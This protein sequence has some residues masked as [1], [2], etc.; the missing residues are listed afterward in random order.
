MPEQ[1]FHH[2]FNP[3][4]LPKPKERYGLHLALFSL[5]FL[6]VMWAGAEQATQW[7]PIFTD[8][9][10]WGRWIGYGLAYAIPFLGFLTVHEFGHYLTARRH[11][12]DAS[13]PYF[14]P[15]PFSLLGI[16]SI[17]TFGAVIRLR[18]T[19][20]RT[21][22]LFDIGI[23]GPLAG[24]V[25]A[26]GA[27]LYGLATLPDHTFV[28]ELPGHEVLKSF[29]AQHG[30]FPNVNEIRTEDGLL[31]IGQ[32]PLYAL[33]VQF[34]PN[35]P[36]MYEMYHYPILMAGWLGLF[37]TALNLMPVGQLDGGHIWYAL[38]G[39]RVHRIVARIFTV[40]LIALGSLGFIQELIP[41]FQYLWLEG[42]PDLPEYLWVMNVGGWLLMGFIQ[43]ALLRG[44]FAENPRWIMPM[45]VLLL[46]FATLPAS[47]EASR[48]DWA[49]MWGE[50]VGQW[51]Y[52]GWLIWGFI[53]VR[54]IRVDHPPVLMPEPLTT[55][56]KI[57]GIISILIFVLCFSFTPIYIR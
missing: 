5:T 19:V 39:P 37:F 48:M 31:M 35:V 55:G 2:D 54:V 10:D 42:F 34:F 12:V 57:L 11:G 3:D 33:L 51:G 52:T 28:T 26:L 47:A 9:P 50:A 30:R 23:A 14:I 44:V 41:S 29:W 7:S 6:S 15:A 36:P 53:I 4:L 25:V 45:L 8:V 20:E 49:R 18:Q 24:F 13:L 1:N 32:T 22:Q 17:G 56:R 21:R 38:A 16:F 46:V 43:W 40:L 27:L